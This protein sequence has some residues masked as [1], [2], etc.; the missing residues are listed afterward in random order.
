MK[1]RRCIVVQDLGILERERKEDQDNRE[2]E[3]QEIRSMEKIYRRTTDE[4]VKNMKNSKS[5]I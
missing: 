4:L 2:R 5:K 3:K 1:L